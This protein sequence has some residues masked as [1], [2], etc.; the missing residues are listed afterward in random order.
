ML[1]QQHD[2]SGCKSEFKKMREP[3]LAK[4]KGG[5]TANASL[6]F[7]SWVKDARAVIVE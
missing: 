5:T 3:K 6:F 2:D 4:L 7:T 1:G